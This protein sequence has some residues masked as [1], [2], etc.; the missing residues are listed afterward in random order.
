MPHSHAIVS[1]SR[2]HP[3]VRST[4]FAIAASHLRHVSPLGTPQHRIA[5]HFQQSLALQDY[6]RALNTP[7]DELGQAGVNALLLSGALL[8]ML[9]FTLPESETAGGGGSDERPDPSTS[10]V[11]SPCE[12]RLDWLALQVGIKPMLVSIAAYFD[13]ALSFVGPI[14]LG[15]EKESWAFGEGARG[16]GLESVPKNWIEVFELDDSTDVPKASNDR[17][18]DAAAPTARP[19]NVFRPA[20]MLL[21][22]L[23]HLEPVRPNVFKNLQFMGKV[24]PAFRTLLYDRDERALWIFG[25][26]LGLMCRFEGLWWCDE[27]VRRDHRAIRMWLEQLRLA[28]RSGVEGM[29]WKEMMEELDL[30]PVY[31]RT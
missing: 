30:A 25:Y 20:A 11:F 4:L 7:R 8:N 12:D 6:Q 10:W 23:R 1:L 26:W 17:K 13:E 15:R 16:Y 31:G 24:Q 28:E 2:S 21:A 14:F 5:E 3:L 9:A 29:V 18:G 19:S 22:Q 27:R